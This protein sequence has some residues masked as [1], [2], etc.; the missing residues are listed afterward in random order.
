MQT[1]HVLEPDEEAVETVVGE[2]SHGCDN[3][4]DPRTVET[5]ALLTFRLIV[6]C[7]RHD[8]FLLLFLTD[9][10]WRDHNILFYSASYLRP[11][12]CQDAPS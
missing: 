4:R 9:A 12:I 6:R 11:D 7:H 3:E 1:G 10:Q 2:L 5:C 8:I